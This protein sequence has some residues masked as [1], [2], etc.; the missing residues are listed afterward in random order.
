MRRRSAARA[1]SCRTPAGRGGSSSAG[2]RA[3]SRAAAAP[4]VPSRAR[5]PTTS[6]SV[7]G[8]MRTASGAV[9][10]R[11]ARLAR[12]GDRSI[13]S[14]VDDGADGDPTLRSRQA[15]S[16]PVPPAGGELAR[17]QRAADYAADGDAVEERGRR[18]AAAAD[19][20]RHRQP[21]GQRARRA[22]APRRRARRR[23]LRVRAARPHRRSARTS[24]RAS[25]ARAAR[26]PCCACSRTSTRCSRRRRSG[27]HDPWSGDLADGFVWGRGALDMKS[28]TAAE[29]VAACSLGARGLAPRARLA[30]ASS[31]VVDEE[32]GGAEGA[33]WLTAH[34]PRQGPLR[35]PPQRGRRR[36]PRVRRPAPVLPRL[37]R[38]GR[39]P[40]RHPHRRRRRARRRCRGSA[41]TRC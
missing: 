7:R 33:Q 12:T 19:P 20:L 35:L 23:R 1:S 5:W 8:R 25:T 21:A 40:L 10:P 27:R 14:G 24:S 3:R 29:V 31:R 34:P 41:T 13:A 26:A 30:A 6:S 9:P 2:G 11:C 4:P 37:R 18:A 32:T 38:E 16:R 22:G 36:H 28:Q 17:P 39:L 15:R